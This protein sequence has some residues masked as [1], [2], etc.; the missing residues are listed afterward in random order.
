[1]HGNVRKDAADCFDMHFW[2][3]NAWQQ[4]T[5]SIEARHKLLRRD[6]SVYFKHIAQSCLYCFVK[7]KIKKCITPFHAF[8][9]VVLDFNPC[10]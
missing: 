7:I 6:F 3:Y 8:E 5:I 9:T 10:T 4:Y 2:P 1:M